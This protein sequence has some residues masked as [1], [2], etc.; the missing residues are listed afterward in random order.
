M[1]NTLFRLRSVLTLF[2][3][4]RICQNFRSLWLQGFP[5][6]VAHRG[7]R[8]VA[9]FELPAA[10]AELPS[11]FEHEGRR[12]DTAQFLEDHW[13]TGLVVLRVPDP[14]RQPAR[15][16][17]LYECYFRGNAASS[18]CISW[19]VGKSFVGA[20]VGVALAE[21]RVK[22]LQDAVTDY[23]P[24]FGGSGYDG[25]TLKNVLQMSSGVGFS[26]DYGR[27]FSDINRMGRA[28][29][30]G[31]S[32]NRL[33]AS[34][35][36]E[37][38][39][40]VRNH[41]CS[42]DTQVLAAVLA[43]V[44][45][46]GATLTQYLEDH[47]WSKVGFE[48][49]ALWLLDNDSDQ[50]ELAFGALLARTRDYARFGWLYLNEGRSPLDGSRILGEEW[51]RQSVVP[52]APHLQPGVNPQNNLWGYG[53][54]LWLLGREGSP[55]EVAGDYMAVGVYNQFVYVSPDD[56][57]VIARNSAYPGYDK[58]ELPSE[59]KAVS[60]F[61]AISAHCSKVAVDM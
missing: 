56:R 38:E 52:D 57:I 5:H 53:Y 32:I 15:A 21:G 37:S 61:R 47:L 23:L 6:R 42:M 46:P 35:K 18:R 49:D 19:S 27:F 4:K 13:T 24:E 50:M 10:F 17:L 7:S 22:S 16:Q 2:D 8:G 26:E 60:C 3:E 1:G 59:A 28:L 30:L 39:Q 51:V 25:V 41:Y 48:D 20:L 12:Y 11:H 31:R 43:R 55:A 40:G 45:G 9:E 54:H 34:L 33:A 58:D 29:A 14:K 44:L 36:R